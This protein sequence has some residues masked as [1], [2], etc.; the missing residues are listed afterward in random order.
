MSVAKAEDDERE[1]AEEERAIEK[2]TSG[3]ASCD[4]EQRTARPNC[5][6]HNGDKHDGI[7]CEATIEARLSK[8][9]SQR[10]QT[11]LYCALHH[12]TTDGKHHESAV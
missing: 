5:C 3:K 1:P 9:L 7:D 4:A 10:K 8:C 2:G 11:L 6:K 12:Q